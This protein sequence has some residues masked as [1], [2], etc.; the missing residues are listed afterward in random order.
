M[1]LSTIPLTSELPKFVLVCPSN[2]GSGTLIDKIAVKPSLTSLPSNAESFSFNCFL[3]LATLFIVRVKAVFNPDKCVP[4]SRVAMLFV[5]VCMFS[6]NAEVHCNAAST[7]IWS[8][9]PV[10]NIGLDIKEVLP[11]FKNL[12]YSE[13]P[14]S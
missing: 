13:I 10:T 3:F 4:P 1:I 6:L 14:P 8:F 12:T 9:S 7:W 5:K 2:W 11:L